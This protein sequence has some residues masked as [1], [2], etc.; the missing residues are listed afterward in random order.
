MRFNW[1]LS[2]LLLVLFTASTSIAQAQLPHTRLTSVFPPG[3]QV[4]TSTDVAITGGKDLDEI[5]TLT[6][7]HPGITAVP[8]TKDQNGKPVAIQ[9]QFVVSVAADVPTGIYEVR[10]AGLF[11]ISTPRSFV[12]GQNAEIRETEANNT[13]ETANVI[14]YDQCINGQVGAAKDVDFY[15]FAGK[16]G[17][18]VIATCH[19]ARID[20]PLFCAIEIYSPSGK[21]LA[22]SRNQVRN[23]PLIDVTLPA[24]GEYIIKLHDFTYAGGI[25]FYY[26]LKISK[27]PYVDFVFPPFVQMGK[28]EKR[29]VYGRNLPGG[30]S[31][32]VSI[33]GR[34]LEKVDIDVTAPSDVTH[35]Q[36]VEHRHAVE[37]GQSFFKFQIPNTATLSA[38]SRIGFASQPVVSEVEPNNEPTQVQGVSIPCQIVGQFQNRGDS[39]LYEFE[40]KA[41][42]TYIF[43]VV[44]QRLGTGVDPTLVVQQIGKDAK[45]NETVKQLKVVDD[46]E[47]NV[48][49]NIFDTRTDDPLYRFQVPAD[50]KYRLLIRDRYF[51]TRGSPEFIYSIVIRRPTPSFRL[52]AVPFQQAP[53]QVVVN[54]GWSMGLRKGGQCLLPVYVNRIDGFNKAIEVTAQ[55]LPAGVTC[56]PAIIDSTQNLTHLVLTAGEEAKLWRGNIQVVGNSRVDAPDKK[57]IAAQ[58]KANTESSKKVITSLKQ[59]ADQTKTAIQKSS[60]QL[61]QLTALLKNDPDNKSLVDQI[62]A[63]ETSLKQLQTQ[64]TQITESQKLAEQS[65]TAA[66]TALQKAEADGSTSTRLLSQAAISGTLLRDSAANI[67]AVSRTSQ[68]LALAILKEEAP[69]QVTLPM[70][71]VDVRQGSQLLIP[72]SLKKRTGFDAEVK[73]THQKLPKNVDA[74][75][76]AIAKGASQQTQRLFFKENVAPGTYTTWIQS[77][78]TVSYRRNIFLLNN[79]KS[80]LEQSNKVL[81]NAQMTAKTKVA[82][83]TASQTALT[84]AEKQLKTAQATLQS[85][86]KA[87]ATAATAVETAKKQKVEANKK[88]AAAIREATKQAGEQLAAI[89][90][91]FQTKSTIGEAEITALQE[92]LKKTTEALNQR[93]TEINMSQ[94]AVIQ[95]LQAATKVLAENQAK[96]AE[97]QKAVATAKQTVDA[98]QKVKQKG[99]AESKQAT[100]SVATATKQVEA[101][102]KHVAEME[103]KT[104]AVA[105]KYFPPSSP[106]TIRVLPAPITLK[107]KS[108]GEIKHGATVGVT[109]TIKRINKFAGPVKLSIPELPGVKGISAKPIE[110]AADQTTATL[111][112]TATKDA[113]EGT[114]PNFVI[115]GTSNFNGEAVVE[116]PVTLK[117]VK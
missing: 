65:L 30:T 58:V 17:E 7:S 112:L 1:Q 56:Q 27:Q 47:T 13:K 28:T 20:S 15:K 76:P 60:E 14:Q 61:P 116:F 98:R 5:D 48:A 63:L 54:T 85:T 62:T 16:A 106:L 83:L 41:K 79:A 44:G 91:Q 81:A 101:A 75:N 90:K 92:Q 26:R 25:D 77:D 107:A 108:A 21:R 43:E 18:R 4:G 40:A 51:E 109:V 111:Q 34:P 64:L 12:V 89:E 102:K 8:K 50:G 86:D 29:T 115:R 100:A 66:L 59:S 9:K 71:K 78:S 67:P 6:F 96:Q 103:K 104:K 57:A 105:T 39:D 3:A 38:T 35:N 32:N 37:A 94:S 24:D 49:P 97:Q 45:G 114:I 117:V 72:V 88:N 70:P 10:A 68:T 42:E 82:K 93:R 69:F 33:D 110:I 80:A 11:G 95:A 52:L 73:L 31:A 87:L 46:N 74:S 84:A 22:Y 2:C 113:A 36:H 99:E 53:G 19:A 55:G 23:D